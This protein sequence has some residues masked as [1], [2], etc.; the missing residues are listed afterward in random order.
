M[1]PPPVATAV[2]VMVVAVV[3]ALL[4][5]LLTTFN[6]VGRYAASH[7]AQRTVLSLVRAYTARPL[8]PSILSSPV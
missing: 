4:G 1:L 5:K 7:E 3:V 2:A 6:A 8:F